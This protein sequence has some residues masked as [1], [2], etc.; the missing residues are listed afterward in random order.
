MFTKYLIAKAEETKIKQ[1]LA[2]NHRE[3]KKL[4][5]ELRGEDGVS[6]YGAGRCQDIE[7]AVYFFEMVEKHIEQLNYEM[8]DLMKEM[9]KA[10]ERELEKEMLFNYKYALFQIKESIKDKKWAFTNLKDYSK[11]KLRYTKSE[12]KKLKDDKT[13]ET[14]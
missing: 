9:P 10:D 12:L 6:Y 3:F 13:R 14:E 5:Y 11:N 8:I 1:D 2:K 7:T 4:E